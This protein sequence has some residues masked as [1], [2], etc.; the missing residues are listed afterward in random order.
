[1]MNK[2]LIDL[3]S[4]LSPKLG[5]S[6]RTILNKAY[7]I[8]IVGYFLALLP[9]P[10]QYYITLRCITCICLFFFFQKIR[11]VRDNHP[12]SYYGII[13]L[14]VLFNPIIPV[15]T[16]SQLFWFIANLLTLY[17]LYNIRQIFEGNNNTKF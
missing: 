6:E 8:L 10:Y 11:G 5:W 17:F 2:F 1:M 13:L 12:M 3:Y 16:G 9:M 4:T 15:H 14:F 7:T